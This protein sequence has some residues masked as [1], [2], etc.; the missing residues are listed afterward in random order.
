IWLRWRLIINSLKGAERRDTLER[1]S[2]V[3]ALIVPG[4][5]V[6]SALTSIVVAGAFGSIGGWQWVTHVLAY[7]WLLRATRVLRLLGTVLAL[8]CVSI[9]PALVST[10]V[11]NELQDQPARRAAS[12]LSLPEEL[13]RW[14]L[15]LPSEM[16]YQA[17]RVA[18][19]RPSRAMT[20]LAALF[21]E[22]G[23]LYWL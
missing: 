8:S 7:V 4:F 1:A 15:V 12:P 5:L 10:R 6:A 23:V 17:V 2:R 18:A 22:G 21:L 13:P 16:Y 19:T 20:P 11:A 3:A 9:V 14:T